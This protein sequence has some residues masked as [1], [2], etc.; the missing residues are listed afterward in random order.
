MMRPR[1]GFGRWNTQT[2]IAAQR[3]DRL[4]APWI[5]PDPINAELLATYVETQLVPNPRARG[6]CELGQPVQP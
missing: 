5:I 3:H 1:R 6:H 4:A 2:F